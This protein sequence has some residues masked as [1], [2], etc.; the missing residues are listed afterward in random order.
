MEKAAPRSNRNSL[1][2]SLWYPEV[3]PV[4]SIATPAIGQVVAGDVFS[5]RCFTGFGYTAEATE[6]LVRIDAFM[7]SDS[8]VHGFRF[9]FDDREPVPAG[10]I[11][12]KAITCII[13]GPGGEKINGMEVLWSNLNK[14]AGLKVRRTASD[15]FSK[16][17]ATQ[18]STNR[19]LAN[20][21]TANVRG[22][23]LQVEKRILKDEEIVVGIFGDT[24]VSKFGI[25]VGR[26]DV[27]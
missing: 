18:I 7:D 24:E 3:P 16:T 25:E 6:H 17:K 2:H 19:R 22:T 15:L 4:N 5:S 27:G 8:S 9:Y 23:D 11:P 26:H 13:D 21:A 20:F 10:W 12:G 1:M 14:I